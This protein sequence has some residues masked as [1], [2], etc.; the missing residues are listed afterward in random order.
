M[1][2]DQKPSE[3]SAPPPVK[4]EKGNQD[5]TLFLHEFVDGTLDPSHLVLTDEVQEYDT[6][7]L[8]TKATKISFRFSKLALQISMA[9]MFQEV[10]PQTILYI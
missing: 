7:I 8:G 9:G 1:H 2:P 10:R 6:R 3:L 4:I 5:F